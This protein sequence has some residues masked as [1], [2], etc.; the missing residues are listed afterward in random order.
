[1]SGPTFSPDGK[2][3]WNGEE[4]IPAPPSIELTISV[5]EQVEK[6]VQDGQDIEGNLRKIIDKC[7]SQNMENELAFLHLR[8]AELFIT[9]NRFHNV[10]LEYIAVRNYLDRFPDNDLELELLFALNFILPFAKNGMKFDEQLKNA[11][12]NLKSN[13]KVRNHSEILIKILQ[14]EIG[15]EIHEELTPEQL[16]TIHFLFQEYNDYVTKYGSEENLPFYHDSLAMLADRQKNY[17]QSAYHAKKSFEIHL[18]L[19]TDTL[20][21]RL[22]L[23]LNRRKLGDFE[24]YSTVAMELFDAWKTLGN[25]V[26]QKHILI[27][28]ISFYENLND[29]DG[30]LI[31]QEKLI[32][33]YQT[34]G[35]IELL[36]NAKKSFQYMIARRDAEKSNQ[37][38]VQSPPNVLSRNVSPQTPN[39]SSFYSPPAVKYYRC[40]KPGCGYAEHGQFVGLKKCLR[41]GSSM[42]HR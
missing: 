19:G 14:W 37:V 5:R 32:D 31:T 15:A 3:M 25:F 10:E 2:W 11:L 20:P 38:S 16:D 39:G 36:E 42:N 27:D 23:H 18:K 21:S 24:G 13:P 17:E 8:L 26:V 22:F 30:A 4:W 9:Q 28:L 6:L 40:M 34:T 7:K 41:C 33:L 1:M 35:S 29:I 12:A